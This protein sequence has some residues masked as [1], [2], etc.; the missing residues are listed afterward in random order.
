MW[1]CLFICLFKSLFI[2]Q[3]N[4]TIQNNPINDK[5]VLCLVFLKIQ[6]KQLELC[7]FKTGC[8]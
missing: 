1:S 8:Q 2:K 7:I 4:K 6:Q 3:T 5:V